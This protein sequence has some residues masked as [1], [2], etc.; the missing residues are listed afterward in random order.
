MENNKRL[1]VA[2]CVSGFIRTWEYTKES[3]KTALC[4]DENI[5]FDLFINLYRQNL[6]EHS[7]GLN[8]V[9]YTDDQIKDMFK[10]FNV[11]KLVTEDLD[12]KHNQTLADKCSNYVNL[13]Y[14]Q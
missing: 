13:P 9:S 5:D 14:F 1:K 2:I 11:K 8:N 4:A 10:E 7:S 6:F 12:E 3:F